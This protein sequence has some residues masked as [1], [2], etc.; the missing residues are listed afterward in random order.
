[1]LGQVAPA[2]AGQAV[3]GVERV[4]AVKIQQKW[5]VVRRAV[6]RRTFVDIHED[7]GQWEWCLVFHCL[8]G[9]PSHDQDDSRKNVVEALQHF[10]LEVSQAVATRS[11]TVR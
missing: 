7:T 11:E 1:M 2:P 6:E 10:H 4:A 5:K 9:E 3:P 8:P